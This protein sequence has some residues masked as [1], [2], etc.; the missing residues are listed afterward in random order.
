MF[1]VHFLSSSC[2]HTS[3]FRILAVF[4]LDCI[5]PSEP[6]T[7][8]YLGAPQEKR[9]RIHRSEWTPRDLFESEHSCIKARYLYLSLAEHAAAPFLV[10]ALTHAQT[11][12]HTQPR[13]ISYV[14][15]LDTLPYSDTGFKTTPTAALN[16]FHLFNSSSKTGLL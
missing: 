13:Y 1:S 11:K 14:K 15:Q 12:L 9:Q 2:S 10:K 4:D 3:R 7:M 8:L 6:S 16:H 5:Q